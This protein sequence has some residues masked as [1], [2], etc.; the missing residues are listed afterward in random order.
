[1][2]FT[3]ALSLVLLLTAAS[4]PVFA[5]DTGTDDQQVDLEPQKDP[6]AG[7]VVGSPSAPV[8]PAVLRVNGEPI[9]AF[10][11]SMIM[12]TIQSQIQ[13]RGGK[14]DAT[15]LA[16]VATQ[17]T[18]EQK[19]LAQE[20][21]RRGL[22]A[23]ELDVARSAEAA[24]KQAGGRASL[25]AKLE[26][27]GATYDELLGVIREIELVRILIEQQIEPNVEVTDEE[28]AAFYKENPSLFE[29]GERVHAFHIVF[30]VSETADES[31]QE[32]A[33]AKAAAARERA[34][35]GV[36]DF[37][38]IA[39]QLSE[40]PTASTGGDLGWVTRDALVGPLAEAVFSLEPGEISEVV[41]SPFGY[42]VATIS[43]RRP[44]ETISLEEATSQIEAALRRDKATEAVTQLLGGLV[45]TARVEN[46]LGNR[47][48]TSSV[49]LD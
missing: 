15:E 37:T 13:Q 9:R 35:A 38:T 1:M 28:I 11:I 23:D 24:E 43:E 3:I 33:R 5:R 14:A 34:V 19:L 4:A 49:E 26:A 12:Q 17:R 47:P 10:E 21:R 40:G 2:R 32:A 27:S 6:T 31:A 30:I 7:S 48:A 46:L 44:A 22:A 42:H 16:K 29:A 41:R 8:N 25:E 45:N 39:K 20:A 18:V 36:E